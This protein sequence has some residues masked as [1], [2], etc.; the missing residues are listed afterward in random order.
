VRD[1]IH[2]SDV[3]DSHVSDPLAL[4][5]GAHRDRGLLGWKPERSELETQI[6]DWMKRQNETNA[7]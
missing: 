3:A 2:V 1:Y 5:G 4:I 7:K 6:E